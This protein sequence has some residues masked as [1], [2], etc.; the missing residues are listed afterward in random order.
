MLRTGTAG[1]AQQGSTRRPIR[2]GVDA[3]PLECE[4]ASS[5]QPV[6]TVLRLFAR[7][8]ASVG[9]SCSLAT[10]RRMTADAPS[11]RA[12]S[13]SP[14]HHPAAT[15]PSPLD[16]VQH[17][18][19]PARPTLVY[20]LDAPRRSTGRDRGRAASRKA[21]ITRAWF[22]SVWKRG[23]RGH[24]SPELR[25]ARMPAEDFVRPPGARGSFRSRTRLADQGRAPRTTGRGRIFTALSAHQWQLKHWASHCG[26]TSTTPFACRARLVMPMPTPATVP[27]ASGWQSWHWF[28]P[29]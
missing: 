10:L 4:R 16:V 5:T 22:S 26:S 6:A 11:R 25:D 1:D 28:P 20:R 13:R 17:L 21:P 27:V 14:P 7:L 2:S 18:P 9:E 15:A 12:G 3:E 23:S 19:A 29:L 24:L 8:G